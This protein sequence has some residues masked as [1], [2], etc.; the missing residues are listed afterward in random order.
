MTLTASV[1]FV[2]EPSHA[3]APY[4]LT[5]TLSCG[6]SYSLPLN[7]QRGSAMNCLSRYERPP[8]TC[9]NCDE[10][11][12]FELSPLE[13]LATEYSEEA[14]EAALEHKLDPLSSTVAAAVLA[15][16]TE[17]LMLEASSGVKTTYDQWGHPRHRVARR[18]RRKYR[19]PLT[20]EVI[21]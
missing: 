20:V 17:E 15:S 18:L 13:R 11:S 8:E 9:R 12:P 16:L 4:H 6:L 21:P 19:Q 5:F 1:T 2:Q 3:Y 10:L 14:L 7:G